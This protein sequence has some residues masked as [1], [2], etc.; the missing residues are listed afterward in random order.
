M[1]EPPEPP[2]VETGAISQPGAETESKRDNWRQ[3]L[4]P[5]EDTGTFN[6]RVPQLE[7][8]VMIFAT[9]MNKMPP[10]LDLDDSPSL[11][12]TETVKLTD[13]SNFDFEPSDAKQPNEMR[14]RMPRANSPVPEQ[15]PLR[16]LKDLSFQKVN[17]GGVSPYTRLDMICASSSCSDF[18]FKQGVLD[19]AGL[20]STEEVP[21]LHSSW[22]TASS[23][24]PC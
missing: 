3:S 4:K 9:S 11:L 15:A 7:N 10:M 22:K 21:Q 2:N 1:S 5:T 12:S 13:N 8:P 18:P 14:M 24:F 6:V 20:I 17:A 19:A 23:E 16:P